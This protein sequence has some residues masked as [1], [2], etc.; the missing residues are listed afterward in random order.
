MAAVI[1]RHLN[2]IEQ[3]QNHCWQGVYISKSVAKKAQARLPEPDAYDEVH[4]YDQSVRGVWH[5]F[6][7]DFRAIGDLPGRTDAYA[8][9]ER[10]YADA[11][12][13]ETVDF[14]Q[15]HLHA[16]VLPK[17]LARGTDTYT[18]ELEDVLSHGPTLTD[19]IDFKRRRLPDLLER[20]DDQK[21][22]TYVF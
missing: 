12:D 17:L 19:W 20:L 9:A 18:S 11:G 3:C 2:R 7:G 15:F 21:E 10:V 14:E 5:E 6:E 22:W 4:V 1:L 8:R 13:P 16:A